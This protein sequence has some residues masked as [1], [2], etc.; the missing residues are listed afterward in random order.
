V[1]LPKS[2]A[3]AAAAPPCCKPSAA[4]ETCADPRIAS[5]VPEQP[6]TSASNTA[7]ADPTSDLPDWSAKSL[8]DLAR[9]E[10][11]GLEKEWALAEAAFGYKA[12]GHAEERLF[13]AG[14]LVLRHIA[15]ES[16]KHHLA[17]SGDRA[18]DMDACITLE[19]AGTALANQR[20]PTLILRM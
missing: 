1:L 13:V 14:R 15:L 3:P 6:T 9:K 18:A 2:P 7:G 19:K 17:E 4:S 11:W 16:W 10:G 5:V 12:S 20:Q 8:R